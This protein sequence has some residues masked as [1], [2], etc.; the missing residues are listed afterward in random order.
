MSHSQF[1]TCAPKPTFT[2]Q[3]YKVNST[4]CSVVN[5]SLYPLLDTDDKVAQ[6]DGA[7]WGMCGFSKKD[8][9]ASYKMGEESAKQLQV[10]GQTI[11][12]NGQTYEPHGTFM[13]SHMKLLKSGFTLVNWSDYHAIPRFA[14]KSVTVVDDNKEW[15]E[16]VKKEFEPFLDRFTFIH[17]EDKRAALKQVLVTEPE[18]I[19]L[20]VH[21]T[22]SEEFDGLWI[23]NQLASFE[24]KGRIALASSYGEESLIAMSKLIKVRVAIPGKNLENIRS[25]LIQSI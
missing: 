19:L 6:T 16:K 14:Y 20:D 12:L 25:L 23:A 5:G 3:G 15:I 17:T 22:A 7:F 9:L 2:E 1:E 11:T 8:A 10:D 21:L 18:A 13:R 24:F 4:R